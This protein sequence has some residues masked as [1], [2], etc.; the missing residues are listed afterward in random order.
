MES[1][2]QNSGIILMYDSTLSTGDAA[3]PQAEAAVRSALTEK[4]EVCVERCGKEFR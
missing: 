1:R 4:T 2:P 3:L